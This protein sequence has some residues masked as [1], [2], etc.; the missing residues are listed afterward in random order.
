MSAQQLQKIDWN[1]TMSVMTYGADDWGSDD[2][3][4]MTTPV[5]VA[6]VVVDHDIGTLECLL[7][8][9]PPWINLPWQPVNWLSIGIF[10]GYSVCRYMK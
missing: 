2:E 7:K 10:I 4:D 9:K 3:C 5:P 8:A 1:P 6:P